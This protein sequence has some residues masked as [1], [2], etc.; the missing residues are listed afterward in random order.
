M[1]AGIARIERLKGYRI[2]APFE[3]EANAENRHIRLFG[4][5]HAVTH[6]EQ[7]GRTPAGVREDGG[8]TRR[9]RLHRKRDRAV[10]AGQGRVT[11]SASVKTPGSRLNAGAARRRS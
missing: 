6:A 2:S 8:S 7:N 5:R 9:V 1:Q 3:V 11:A 4:Q 10:E